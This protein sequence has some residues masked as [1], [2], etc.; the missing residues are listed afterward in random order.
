MTNAYVSNWW[1]TRKWWVATV[2]AVGGL[3]AT[4]AST[5]WDWTNEFTGAVITLATQ[6]LVAYLVRNDETP[7]GVPAA[8]GP[9]I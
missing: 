7:G 6:R 4:L 8:T 5:G 3:L 1:P 2:T 9:K